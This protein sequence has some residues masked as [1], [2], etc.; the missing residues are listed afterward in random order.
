MDL[1]L[2]IAWLNLPIANIIFGWWAQIS[3][4]SSPLPVCGLR[5]ASRFIIRGPSLYT[6]LTIGP[7]LL[8]DT[9]SMR[10]IARLL[11]H[12]WGSGSRSYDPRNPGGV[13]GTGEL[14]LAEGS[15]V[16]RA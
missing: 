15:A 2:R 16:A 10:A 13:T 8:F 3:I 9:P 1:P 4:G 6:S 14:E 5:P 11:S 12:G 7:A